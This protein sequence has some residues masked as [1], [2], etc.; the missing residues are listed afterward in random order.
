MTWLSRLTY[1]LQD[2]INIHENDDEQVVRPSS[3]MLQEK[4]S[5]Y[6]DASEIRVVHFERR[7]VPSCLSIWTNEIQFVLNVP[8]YAVELFF[9]SRVQHRALGLSESRNALLQP[10]SNKSKYSFIICKKEK[11]AISSNSS[12]KW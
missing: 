8:D 7:V 3:I 1:T 9:F 12:T 6:I 4:S 11:K 10:N 2:A 5:C